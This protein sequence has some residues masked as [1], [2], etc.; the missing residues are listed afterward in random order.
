MYDY[1]I[2]EMA[3]A[4]AKE[5]HVDNNDALRVLHQYWQ[6]KIAD[7]WQVDQMLEC[8]CDAGK[9]ITRADAAELLHNVFEDYDSEL[10]INWMTLGIEVQEYHL[11]LKRLPP[12]QYNEV[13]GVFKVWREGNPISHQFGLFPNQVDGNFPKALEFAKSMADETPGVPIF[14][15]CEPRR[16][17]DVEPWLSVL[18]ENDELRVSEDIVSISGI[19]DPQNSNAS[20]IKE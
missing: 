16:S 20:N 3:D 14:I 18:R 12:D 11:S 5:L 6:D 8:A 17:E 19:S 4:I 10:G 13:H 1:M 7:V 2:E 9:P 15:G